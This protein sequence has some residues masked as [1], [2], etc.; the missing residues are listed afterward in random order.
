MKKILT[1]LLAL[2]LCFAFVACGGDTEE[3]ATDEPQ[4]TVDQEEPADEPED[5]ATMGEKN[6]LAKAEQYL[7][8][9]AFSKSGLADQLEY[10]GFEASEIEYAV[11]NCGANWKEQAA[12]K[13]QEYLDSQS[14]SKEGLIEQLEYEG[15]TSEQAAYGVDK[16][17]K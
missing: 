2:S 3:P 5:D 9:M 17:Y 14:F 10:E 16:V 11:E 7:D 4:Q 12:L 15:F 1:L 6:A 13:A 8:S